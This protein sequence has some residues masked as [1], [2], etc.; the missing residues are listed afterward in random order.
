[1]DLGLTD[2]QATGAGEESQSAAPQALIDSVAR[3]MVV[4]MRSADEQLYQHNVNTLLDGLDTLARALRGVEGRKQVLYF[5]AGFDARVLVGQWGAEQKAAGEAVTSGRLWEV[6][7]LGRFGDSRVRER[8]RQTRRAAS[9][10]PTRS[11]TRSTSP[12]S[13]ATTR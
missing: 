9:R 1:M 12:A 8:A 4:R 5:S 6:D 7:S 13:A 10:Q 3:V 11:C 2:L